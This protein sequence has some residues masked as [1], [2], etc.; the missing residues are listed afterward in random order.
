[1]GSTGVFPFLRRGQ[2]V[3]ATLDVRQPA[4]ELDCLL[5]GDILHGHFSTEPLAVARIETHDLFEFLLSHFAAANKITGGDFDQVLVFGGA[6]PA[7]PAGLPM[8][9]CPGGMRMRRMPSEFV[10]EYVGNIVAGVID[11]CGLPLRQWPVAT[12]HV[13]TKRAAA[14]SD[15]RIGAEWDAESFSFSAARSSPAIAFPEE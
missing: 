2:A 10:K 9:N 7:S 6:R 5:P 13:A 12:T 8:T 15:R 3:P 4:T 1:M 14:T 11:D